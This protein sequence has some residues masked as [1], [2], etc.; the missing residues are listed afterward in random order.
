MSLIISGIIGLLLGLAYCYWKQIQAAY[1]AR[2]VI[3]SG[4]TFV[5]ASQDFYSSLKK[6]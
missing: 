3:A 6:L 2:D 1:A 5:G 4:A